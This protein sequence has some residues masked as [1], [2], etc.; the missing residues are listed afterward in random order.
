MPFSGSSEFHGNS[1]QV[2]NSYAIGDNCQN[3]SMGQGSR[4][5]TN[6]NNK[7]SFSGK[8]CTSVDF[9]GTTIKNPNP[10][11]K[12]KITIKWEGEE[13]IAFTCPKSLDVM[14]KGNC[15]KATTSKGNITIG[16]DCENA[17]TEEGGIIIKGSCNRCTSESGPITVKNNKN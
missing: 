2:N 6:S 14:I 1:K 16:G 15:K 8:G 13:K 10:K 7:S 11:G 5:E 12:Y 9:N 4:V 3:I 17:V